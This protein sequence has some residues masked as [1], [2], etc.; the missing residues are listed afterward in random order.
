MSRVPVRITHIRGRITPL[1]T[2][3]EPPSTSSGLR[4][5]T[6]KPFSSLLGVQGGT[7]NSKL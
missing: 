2:T 6:W 1:V 5:V 7:L 4:I 3:H